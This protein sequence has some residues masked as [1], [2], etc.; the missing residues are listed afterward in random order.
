[1]DPPDSSAGIPIQKYGAIV[2]RGGNPRSEHRDCDGQAGNPIPSPPRR[3]PRKMG[4]VHDRAPAPLILEG[5]GMGGGTRIPQEDWYIISSETDFPTCSKTK[6]YLNFKEH[7]T[8]EINIITQIGE[9]E[10]S[11]K[12]HTRLD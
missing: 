3:G 2:E 4:E 10:A 9:R 1:M 6:L 7:Q 11:P 8:R 5:A 12:T